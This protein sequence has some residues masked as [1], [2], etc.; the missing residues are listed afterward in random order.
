MG[1]WECHELKYKKCRENCHFT[2]GLKD[3]FYGYE[4]VTETS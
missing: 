1:G 3:S 4:K 2:E